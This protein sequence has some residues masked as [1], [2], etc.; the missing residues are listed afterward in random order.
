MSYQ[1]SIPNGILTLN[2]VDFNCP[3]CGHLHEESDY[4]KKL[5]K[6]DETYIY[7]KCKSCK[8]KLGVT[9]DYRGDVVVWLKS[10][11]Q[12]LLNEVEIC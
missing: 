3:K 6:S 1:I 12:E 8:E 5:E 7:M 10:K 4:Y 11:E 2:D 9:T